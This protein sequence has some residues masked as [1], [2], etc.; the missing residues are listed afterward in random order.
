[1]FIG[2]L[3]RESS[4]ANGAS[5]HT[6]LTEPRRGISEV[7]RPPEG[8]CSLFAF[9]AVNGGQRSRIRRSYKARLA[10]STVSVRL[11]LRTGN[12]VSTYLYF[13]VCWIDMGL[14]DRE[15][16]I[17]RLRAERRRTEN[18]MM[19]AGNKSR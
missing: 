15:S 11:H 19:V 16:R 1:M 18:E 12:S 10:S 8:T 4:G 17:S 7:R 2:D 13:V 5:T 3:E 9:S 14:A 6:A